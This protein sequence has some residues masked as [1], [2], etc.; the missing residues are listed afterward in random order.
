VTAWRCPVCEGIN[1]GGRVCTTCGAVLAEDRP[2]P[3]AARVRPPATIVPLLPPP[4]AS[5]PSTPPPAPRGRRRSRPVPAA[6]SEPLP[7]SPAE[8]F[9]SDPFSY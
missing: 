7:P 9:G 5:P 6:A 4:S 8:I 2:L 1:E 3:V